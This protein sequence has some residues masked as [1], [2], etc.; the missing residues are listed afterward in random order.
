MIGAGVAQVTVGIVFPTVYVTELAGLTFPTKSCEFTV[1]VC[2]PTVLST[3]LVNVPVFAV[4][5]ICALPEGP[6][7]TTP[8]PPS[9][10]LYVAVT[11]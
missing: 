3:V 6:H 7:S 5:G 2:V 1:K 8:D 11:V 10:Q 9:E 4:G